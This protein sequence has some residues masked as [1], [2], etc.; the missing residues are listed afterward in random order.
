MMT[1]VA[2]F[3]ELACFAN[4]YVATDLAKVRRF[5]NN[6]KFSIRENIVGYHLQEFDS[7]VETTMIIKREAEDARGIWEAGAKDKKKM[8]QFS[9]SSSERKQTTSTPQ[10]YQG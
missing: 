8:G 5:E 9:Y 1:Y 7:M 6:L 4:D 3:T 2:K 10:G